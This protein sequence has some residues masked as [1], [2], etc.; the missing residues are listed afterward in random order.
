V[1]TESGVAGSFR[2][3][4]QRT[5][6]ILA[7]IGASTAWGLGATTSDYVLSS[8]MGNDTFLVLELSVGFAVLMAIGALRGQL[9]G[10]RHPGLARAAATGLIEPW[11]AYTLGNIGIIFSSGA[12]VALVSSL[13]PVLVALLALPFLGERVSRTAAALMVVSI[14]GVGLVIGGDAFSGSL[15]PLGILFAVLGL[16]CGATYVL[17]SSKL[18]RSVPVLPLVSLQLLVACLASAGVFVVR[19][20]LLGGDPGVP[21]EFSVW[22]VAIATGIFG[23]AAPFILLLEATKRIPTTTTAQFGTL[24]PVIALVGGVLF[25]GDQPSGF[26]LLGT[27]IVVAALSAL[28]RY[29]RAH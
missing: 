29:T 24:V 12:F 11:G 18:V 10:F 19:V 5:V 15:D 2:G 8:G 22:A 20:A 27:A 6:G 17:V 4:S 14:G 7:A 9:G 25:L 23:G 28:A 26:Q 3:R 16:F 21:T 13:N 1:T